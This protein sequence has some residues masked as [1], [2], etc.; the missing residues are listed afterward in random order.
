MQYREMSNWLEQTKQRIQDNK[1]VVCGGDASVL[2]NSF[3]LCRVD[4]IVLIRQIYKSES[5]ADTALE[6]GISAA[7]EICIDSPNTEIATSFILVEYGGY[8][9]LVRYLRRPEI[10]LLEKHFPRVMCYLQEWDSRLLNT[11]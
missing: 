3:P 2:Y 8:E 6:A 10:D 1:C 5:Y 9:G 7:R 11:P 4:D